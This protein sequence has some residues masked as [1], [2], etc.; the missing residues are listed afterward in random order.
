MAD[1]LRSTPLFRSDLVAIHDVA[2]RPNCHRCGGVECSHTASITFVRR[3]VFVRHRARREELADP[4]RVVF[5]RPDDPY[6]VSHPIEGGDDCTA[7]RFDPDVLRE[8]L[9]A[10]DLLDR[11]TREIRPVR[12]DAPLSPRSQA[13]FRGL[14]KA[15]HDG[16]EALAIEEAALCLL[17]DILRES[18]P[19]HRAD[20]PE[21]RESTR[22]AHAAAVQRVLE[23]LAARPGER[24]SLAQLARLAFSSRF[25]LARV[26]RSQTGLS[27]HEHQ[28]RLRLSCVLER[29]ADGADDLAR[30]ALDVGFSSHS[31]LT[32]EFARHVGCTPSDFRRRLSTPLLRQTSTILQAARTGCG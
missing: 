31:H 11:Q 28:T 30:L 7:I 22:S 20:G 1:F 4:T 25:H 12:A 13:E 26:F 32:R 27:I 21:R 5:F 8:A 16:G 17:N 2:C 19:R 3:G 24:L 29:L 15:A 14:R 18:S 9:A 23:A 10:H 6:R